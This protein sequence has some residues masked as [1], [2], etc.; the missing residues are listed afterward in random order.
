MGAGAGRERGKEDERGHAV[1]NS[2][3]KVSENFR[4][5]SYEED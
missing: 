4:V 5:V 2:T 3:S 1:I